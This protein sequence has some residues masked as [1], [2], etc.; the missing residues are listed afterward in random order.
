MKAKKILL[1]TG[2]GAGLFLSISRL[3][4]ATGAKFYWL[5]AGLIS[6]A[7]ILAAMTGAMLGNVEGGVYDRVMQ[8]RLSS[9]LPA[10]SIIILDIDEKSLATLAPDH[11]RW[12][13]PRE[14]MAMAIAELEQNGARAIAV[15]IMFTD[16]DINNPDSDALLDYIAGAS[17]TAVFPLLRLPADNDR[18]SQ[19]QAGSIPG[20]SLSGAD[21][22][23]VA[24]LL[25]FLPG[26]QQSMGINNLH[27]DNDGIVRRASLLHS[28]EHWSM[29]TLIGQML[30]L[31]GAQQL[32]AQQPYYLNWR[33]KRG[34]YERVSFSDFLLALD[35][36]GDFDP[37][38]FNG[39]YVILGASAP[40]ISSLKPTAVSP[41]MDDNEILATALDDAL[42]YSH[43]RLLPGWFIAAMAIAFTTLMAALF[44]TKKDIRKLDVVFVILEGAGLIVLFVS[45]SFTPYFIDLA[46]AL[47][48]GL[49]YFSIARL[50]ATLDARVVHG[51][52][53]QFLHL[54]QTTP[55]S[56]SLTA[57]S[58]DKK[59][60]KHWERNLRRLEQSFGL[61]QVFL[62]REPFASDRLAGV[63]NDIGC[64]VVNSRELDAQQLTARV[65]ELLY[66]DC[67]QQVLAS[68]SHEI[69]QQIRDD[70]KGL[71]RLMAG[72]ILQLIGQQTATK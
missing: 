72:H 45:V 67:R 56:F 55:R 66:E 43:I 32:S 34:G 41:L 71:R 9:P 11:G 14:I 5:L 26:M 6:A 68:S 39:K 36:A 13:W 40:G 30:Q 62:L 42:H 64:L 22:P 10:D 15:N 24:V 46:P 59:R 50:Y 7:A 38:Y 61:G 23:P 29:P 54:S 53:E 63:F 47:T 8:L 70:S 35:G 69:P 3:C 44:S 4:H 57:Y 1:L 2:A 20:A 16:A 52:P 48:A 18:H 12:P 31:S 60:Q 25:P 33:N 27:S 17:N 58:F 21:N 37:A 49:A 19:L 51:A 28:E 65:D